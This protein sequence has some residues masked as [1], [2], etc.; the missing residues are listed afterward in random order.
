YYYATGTLVLSNNTIT[1]PEF[2]I[3]ATGTSAATVLAN[4]LP[5]GTYTVSVYNITDYASNTVS[6][7]GS[8]TK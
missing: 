7:N 3:G 6:G 4:N 1:V 5:S 2:T 8:Y